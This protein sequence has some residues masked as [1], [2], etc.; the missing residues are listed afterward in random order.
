MATIETKAES[1]SIHQPGRITIAAGDCRNIK[2]VT[3]M[4]PT[5]KPPGH[6]IHHAMCIGIKEGAK[7]PADRIRS[8]VV[9]QIHIMI[10]VWNAV[11]DGRSDEHTSD[12]KSLIRKPY[13]VFGLKKKKH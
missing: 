13:A 4:D 7:H 2:P 5:V 12:L 1:T 9:V 8:S 11:N 3:G 6:S 10:N